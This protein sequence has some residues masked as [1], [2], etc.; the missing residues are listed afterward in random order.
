[1]ETA[2]VSGTVTKDGKPVSG[3]TITFAPKGEEG[4]AS[5]KPA[6]GEV[7]SDGTYTLTTYDDGDGA[8]IGTH[9]VSYDPP[10]EEIKEPEEGGHDEVAETTPEALAPEEKEVTVEAGSNTIEIKLVPASN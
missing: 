5:G 8:V 3:G 7:Q 2:S 9:E 6:T 1:M 10:P 4:K